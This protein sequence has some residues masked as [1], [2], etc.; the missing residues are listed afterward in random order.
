MDNENKISKIL[1][2]MGLVTIAVGIIGSLIS[3]YSEY[4]I[5]LAIIG[6]IGSIILGML[7]IGFSEVINLLQ[8][9]VYNQAKIIR[10][11]E[12]KPTTVIKNTETI[13]TEQS[14]NIIP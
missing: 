5:A 10:Q 9:S 1:E 7:S 2:I 14:A 12:E 11:L 4:N 8:Q 13:S 6:I 3:G